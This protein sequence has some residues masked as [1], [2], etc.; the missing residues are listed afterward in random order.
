MNLALLESV[1]AAVLPQFDESFSFRKKNRQKV[2]F[3]SSLTKHQNG[4]KVTILSLGLK[5][6]QSKNT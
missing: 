5:K 4:V 6:N 1:T 3:Q 2:V